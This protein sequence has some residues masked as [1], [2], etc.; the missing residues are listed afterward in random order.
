[1]KWFRKERPTPKIVSTG[2]SAVTWIEASNKM[3]LD[4][5]EIGAFPTPERKVA[6]LD[7]LYFAQEREFIAVPGDEGR[8]VVF[9]DPSEGRNSKMAIVFSDAEVTGGDD[10]ATCFVEAGMASFFTPASVDAMNQFGR[11][12]GENANFYDD[13]FCKFD[14]E[15]GGERKLAALPDGT[16]VPYI[17]SGWGDGAYP[18]FTLTDAEGNLCAIYT[19][20][21]GHNDDGVY[22][23]PPG[24][25]VP[26]E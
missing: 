14:D 12:L 6:V 23:T 11:S 21:M 17:H 19:D 16:L 4:V 8:V 20:F 9:H 7:P 5:V 1:M 26:E 15:A 2:Q 18:V 10:V 24:F 25:V 13:Y 22:L 3:P